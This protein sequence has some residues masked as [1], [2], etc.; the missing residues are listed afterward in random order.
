LILKANHGHKGTPPRGDVDPSK[1]SNN[2]LVSWLRD[3]WDH[4]GSFYSSD[5]GGFSDP[6]KLLD[7]VVDEFIS[8]AHSEDVYGV[9]F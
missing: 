1:V 7:D 8:V 9:F 3:S 6:L 5:G 4:G 2:S